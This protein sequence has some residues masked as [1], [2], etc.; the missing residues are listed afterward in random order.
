MSREVATPFARSGR[1]TE[2]SFC[3]LQFAFV[4]LHSSFSWIHDEKNG[5][6]KMKN[7]PC[8]T[9]PMRS[10]AEASPVRKLSLAL[11]AVS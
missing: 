3:L 7:A 11:S 1:A 10:R 4:I 5:K 6:C 8:K 9:R 2:V